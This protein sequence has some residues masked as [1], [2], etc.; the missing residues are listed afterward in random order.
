M[1][2]T[3]IITVEPSV[4]RSSWHLCWSTRGPLLKVVPDPN[5]PAVWRIQTRDGHLSDMTNLARAK[6][7]SGLRVTGK[8]DHCATTATTEWATLIGGCP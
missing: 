4:N 6:D 5:W 7:H 3:Y 1:S 2:E 8:V